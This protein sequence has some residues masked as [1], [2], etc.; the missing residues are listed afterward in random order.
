MHARSRFRLRSKR[1]AALGTGL[2]LFAGVALGSG[3]GPGASFPSVTLEAFDGTTVRLDDLRGRVR[4]VDFWASW[5]EVCKEALPR[6]DA[7]ARRHA[8]SGLSVLAVSIDDDRAAAERWIAARLPAPAL[9]LL[10]DPG[11]ALLA[12]LGGSTLPTL[13]VLDREGRIVA[14]ESGYGEET[15]DAV[16]A[17]V[18]RLLAAEVP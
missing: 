11:G 17:E 18:E 3:A 14:V 1:A 16:A 8:G 2:A 12:R 7:L 5:C 15:L 10:R 9:R 6:L 13:Y 4:I